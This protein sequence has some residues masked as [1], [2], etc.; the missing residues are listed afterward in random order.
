MSKSERRDWLLIA[1]LAETSGVDVLNQAFVDAYLEATKAP[2]IPM[3][4]GAHKCKTLGH[5]LSELRTNGYLSRA[6]VGIPSG[7]AEGFP[8][9]VYV[10]QL[11]PFGKDAAEYTKA[12]REA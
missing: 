4:Y 11:T 7:R 6:R 2:F 3:H 9:W 8:A 10:Y 5:D 1:M 12:M